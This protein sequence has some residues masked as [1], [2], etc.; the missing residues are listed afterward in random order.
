MQKKFRAWYK[1][2]LK[3][4]Y[5]NEFDYLNDDQDSFT[6]TNSIVP[7]TDGECYLIKHTTNS[8]LSVKWL[9]NCVIEQFT[10]LHDKNGVEIYEGDILA[11]G[12]DYDNPTTGIVVFDGNGFWIV[13]ANQT[14][15]PNIKEVIGN[16]HTNKE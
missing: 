10:G 2:K 13:G 5:S 15:M 3:Y 7:S 1:E 9:Q 14:H 16:I 11:Y 12:D 8:T 6:C 4:I